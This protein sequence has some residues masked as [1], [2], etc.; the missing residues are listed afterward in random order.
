MYF[1]AR[2]IGD[3][4]IPGAGAYADHEVGAAV[5]TGDGDVMMRFL[6]RW[7]I[8]LKLHSAMC[9]FCSFLAV[10]EMRRGS[11]PEYA[12][13]VAI[14]RIAKYYPNFVGAVIAVKKDGTYGIACNGLKSFPYIIANEEFGK[15][16]LKANECNG[17]LTSSHHN[18]C[19]LL[20]IV[21]AFLLF[22]VQ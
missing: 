21:L 13:H 11:S 8:T 22:V 18:Y 19:Y 15:A 17:A 12:A 10:E 16:T 2:R 5:G 20:M 14:Q 9:F 6:P 1:F 7:L 4:P 3:S